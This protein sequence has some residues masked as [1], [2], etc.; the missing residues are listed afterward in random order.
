MQ[1][2]LRCK[3]ARG[4]AEARRRGGAEPQTHGGR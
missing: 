3:R 2:A 4:D 1:V